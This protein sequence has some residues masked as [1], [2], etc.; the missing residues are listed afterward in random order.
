MVMLGGGESHHYIGTF[1][2]IFMQMVLFIE[3]L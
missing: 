1:I 3:L 2:I